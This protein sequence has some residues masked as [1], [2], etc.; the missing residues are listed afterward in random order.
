MC[1]RIACLDPR[2][3]V[4]GDL[5]VG[6]ELEVVVEA[7]LDR[8]AD[9]HLG[10]R[11]ELEHRLGHHVG[12]V[13]ADQ[14]Q[15]LGVAV[16]EDRRSPPRSGSGAARSRSSPST[17]IASAALASP[18]PIAAAASAPVAPAGSSSGLPS[19]RVTV[20]LLR[21]GLHRG[22]GTW[23]TPASLVCGARASAGRAWRA[24]RT[25]ISG[26]GLSAPTGPVASQ[27]T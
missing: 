26:H 21:R 18:G 19:G 13:V 16:G 3:V 10:P 1:S 9:R 6:R 25:A 11:V 5:G 8:R 24:W 17:R 27:R 20:D 7:G 4:L 2:Q 15:R 23:A 12:G 14:L 22:H